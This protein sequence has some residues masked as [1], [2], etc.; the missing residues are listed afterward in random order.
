MYL[1]EM[2]WALEHGDESS[3]SI[4][5][6]DFLYAWE[7]CMQGFGWEAGREEATGKT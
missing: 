4:K 7:K 1:R 3:D 6:E 2:G 5:G